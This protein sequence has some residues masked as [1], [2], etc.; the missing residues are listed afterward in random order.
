MALM[1]PP[2]SPPLLPHLPKKHLPRILPTKSFN[3]K[4]DKII[5]YCVMDISQFT[6]NAQ[7]NSI[8]SANMPTSVPEEYAKFVDIFEP[9]NAQKLPPH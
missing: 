3:P 4:H 8:S 5:F 9:K 1:T 6:P 2:S 7:V